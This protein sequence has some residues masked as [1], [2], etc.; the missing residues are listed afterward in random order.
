MFIL[1]LSD[2]FD[3]ASITQDLRDHVDAFITSANTFL[4]EQIVLT[5]LK[6]C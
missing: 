6:A 4:G 1:Q 3:A 5:P 2:L